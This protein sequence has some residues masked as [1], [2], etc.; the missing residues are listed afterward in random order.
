MGLIVHLGTLKYLI[1]N[2]D[3]ASG[4]FVYFVV[5]HILKLDAASGRLSFE[6]T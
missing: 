4:S 3:A 2:L 6:I 5:Y 1:L